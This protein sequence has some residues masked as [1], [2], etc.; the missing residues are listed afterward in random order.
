MN[1][2]AVGFRVAAV[3]NE[4]N[5][6]ERSGLDAYQCLRDLAGEEKSALRIENHLR[7]SVAEDF[8]GGA[9]RLVIGRLNL[10]EILG[11]DV[12]GAEL[13]V[14]AGRHVLLDVELEC[15]TG[16]ADEN[17]H[18]AEVHDIASIAAGI[19]HGEL[20]DC[21]NHI[22]TAARGDYSRTAP[23]FGGDS[24]HYEYREYQADQRIDL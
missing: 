7:L 9:L 21:G 24:Q 15:R 4:I 6:A 1:L 5:V 10:I 19:A 20:A 2:R 11:D 13:H 18:H 23:K 8:E 17:Q 16:N 3:V 22:D 14:R 12:V